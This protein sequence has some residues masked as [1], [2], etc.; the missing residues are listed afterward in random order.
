M[1]ARLAPLFLAALWLAAP[2]AGAPA[3]DGADARPW[4]SERTHAQSD[5][6]GRLRY[7]I[8]G[9]LS[10]LEGPEGT[11]GENS[12]LPEQLLWDGLSDGEGPGI[13]A[14]ARFELDDRNWLEGRWMWITGWDDTVQQTG[15]F[16]FSPATGPATAGAAGPGGISPSNTGTFT[17]D[18]EAHS[19]EINWWRAWADIE[20]ARVDSILGFRFLY[21][22]ERASAH[23]WTADFGNG[24]N[25]FVSSL[26]ES[27]FF[28]AQAGG[29]VT[30]RPGGRSV[31]FFAAVKVLF[32]A[33][34]RNMQ[35]TE[36]GFFEDML[37]RPRIENDNF[38][39]GFDLDVAV[40]IWLR[41]RLAV[42]VG[43][44]LLILDDLVRAHDALDFSRADS[45][46]IPP[47]RT[48][49]ELVLHSIFVGVVLDF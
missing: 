46:T 10:L 31:E 47:I 12:G 18:A 42:T 23:S 37:H 38:V 22:R 15:V 35:V 33:L 3:E 26:V 20:D 16:G 8:E 2:A 19:V 29:A 7:T 6:E 27:M 21:V 30:Y 40:R 49:D 24:A 9:V 32:G 39:I 25:P 14:A 41:P 1:Q 17:W 28:G 4:R 48:P 34:L 11:F 36:Q 45:G 5:L 44:N 43:Y 13:R